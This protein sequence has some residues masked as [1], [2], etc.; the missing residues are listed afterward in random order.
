MVMGDADNWRAGLFADPDL[1]DYVQIVDYRAAL[2][3]PNDNNKIPI[4]LRPQDQNSASRTGEDI[5]DVTGENLL[6]GE[7]ILR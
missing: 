1:S 2:D 5:G 4:S 6:A 3:P 7:V